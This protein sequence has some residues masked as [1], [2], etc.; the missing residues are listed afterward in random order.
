MGGD[1]VKL[2]INKLQPTS[3]AFSATSYINYV[4]LSLCHTSTLF[5]TFHICKLILN[6]DEGRKIIKEETRG[7]KAL[8]RVNRPSIKL[9]KGD[10]TNWKHKTAPLT[11]SS[12]REINIKL[13]SSENENPHFLQNVNQRKD[14]MSQIPQNFPNRQKLHHR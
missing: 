10:E 14:E 7:L 13:C 12:Q 9:R 6:Y 2:G 8:L 11:P 3:W 5:P 1:I 4:I